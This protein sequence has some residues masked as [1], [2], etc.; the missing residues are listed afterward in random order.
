MDWDKETSFQA[1]AFQIPGVFWE[2]VFLLTISPHS[3]L[4]QGGRSRL[5][6]RRTTKPRSPLT[7]A[8]T[9]YGKRGQVRVRYVPDPFFRPALGGAP[10]FDSKQDQLGRYYNHERDI[11]GAILADKFIRVHAGSVGVPIE[12]WGVKYDYDNM[13]PLKPKGDPWA[14]PTLGGN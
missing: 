14:G 12:S 6:T 5:T 3:F 10:T 4:A 1:N 13:P 8:A 2:R 7:P 9:C 11:Q